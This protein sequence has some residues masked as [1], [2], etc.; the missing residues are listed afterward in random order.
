MRH[1]DPTPAV[2]SCDTGSRKRRLPAAT[3]ERILRVWSGLR[4]LGGVIAGIGLF[5]GGASA[6]GLLQYEVHAGLINIVLFL[7]ILVAL[8]LLMRVFAL[9]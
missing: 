6:A 4:G 8:P 1:F 2:R 9:A 7:G 3:R 5:L